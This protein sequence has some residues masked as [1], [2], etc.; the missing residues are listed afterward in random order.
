MYDSLEALLSCDWMPQRR[1]LNIGVLM[2][3]LLASFCVQSLCFV[4]KENRHTN[5]RLVRNQTQCATQCETQPEPEEDLSSDCD[6]DED[7]VEARDDNM[8]AGPSTSTNLCTIL[9]EAVQ[10]MADGLSVTLQE[11]TLEM[12]DHDHALL[13]DEIFLHTEHVKAR[14]V[15]VS[16]ALELGNP[17]S[18][19]GNK[20]DMFWFKFNRSSFEKAKKPRKA[21]VEQLESKFP[22]WLQEY[23]D[24]LPDVRPARLGEAE[25]QMVKAYRNN[26]TLYRRSLELK[27]IL[28]AIHDISQGKSDKALTCGIG[29]IRRKME[30]GTILNSPLLEID[31]A[32]RDR[33]NRYEFSPDS[34]FAGDDP[35]L[36]Q[37]IRL[38][39]TLSKLESS[40]DPQDHTL[41]KNAQKILEH[42]IQC[43]KR[44]EKAPI[45]PFDSSTYKSLLKKI[46]EA[47]DA[48]FSKCTKWSDLT[49]DERA[50]LKIDQNVGSDLQ[51]IDTWVVFHRPKAQ[52]SRIVSQDAQKFIEQL[53]TSSHEPIPRLWEAVVSDKATVDAAPCQVQDSEF[54][55]ALKQNEAQIEIL[56]KLESNDCVVV[57]GPPGTGKS[58]T[59]GSYSA[60]FHPCC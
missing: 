23:R 35:K 2:I 29:I 16:P 37:K 27:P 15:G 7:D 18:D 51:I 33:N 40:L 38:C 54:L 11:L 10:P 34:L 47:L 6:C 44:K 50:N 48:C 57:Q 20:R 12:L 25:D 55:L 4:V 43:P 52:A 28:T 14:E 36:N 8:G 46:G 53:R 17:S 21:D 32:L 3:E 22:A 60:L 56:K 45:N 24:G 58:H 1:D 31:L 30:N 26:L 49:L 5:T 41:Q 19:E 42:F 59:I 39:A 9:R 13:L